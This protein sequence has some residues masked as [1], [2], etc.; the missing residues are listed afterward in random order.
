MAFFSNSTLTGNRFLPGIT[1][2][3]SAMQSISAGLVI[4]VSILGGFLMY[5]SYTPDLD[6]RAPAFTKDALPLIGSWNFFVQKM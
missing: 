4:S 1:L 2:E 3:E 6:K 5:L